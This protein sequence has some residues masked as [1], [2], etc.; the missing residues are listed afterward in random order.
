MIADGNYPLILFIIIADGVVGY[1]LVLAEKRSWKQVSLYK[2]IGWY[3]GLFEPGELPKPTMETFT[4]D[5]E[6]WERTTPGV[7]TFE[8]NTDKI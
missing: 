5:M 6:P 7:Q 2:L 3:L 8:K 1:G 4:K